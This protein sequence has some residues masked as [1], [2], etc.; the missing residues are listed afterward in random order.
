MR[1][2][3]VPWL[4]VAA[5]LTASSATK[6]TSPSTHGDASKKSVFVEAEESFA[7]AAKQRAASASK[8]RAKRKL[9]QPKRKKEQPS[10]QQTRRTTGLTA[11]KQAAN[12]A[13]ATADAMTVPASVANDVAKKGKE[14]NYKR[15]KMERTQPQT[16]NSSTHQTQE[17]NK[18]YSGNNEHWNTGR[19]SGTHEIIVPRDSAHPGAQVAQCPLTLAAVALRTLFVHV[20]HVFA[21][22]HL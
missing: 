14:D 16:C 18:N 21:F 17:A 20:A 13:N 1:A 2:F 3:S 7:A 9:P 22:C 12:D 5:L 8:Q 4:L 10:V 15:A 11:A 6:S 19:D